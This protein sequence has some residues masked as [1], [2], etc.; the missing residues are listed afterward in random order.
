[1]GPSVIYY[2]LK[3]G[4]IVSL[5]IFRSIISISE[6][7]GIC[8]YTWLCLR[9]KFTECICALK[10]GILVSPLFYFWSSIIFYWLAACIPLLIL[11]LFHF[12]IMSFA[13][14]FICPPCFPWSIWIPKLPHFTKFYLGFYQ[15]CIFS[16]NYQGQSST[17]WI[18]WYLKY[19]FLDLYSVDWVQLPNQLHTSFLHIVIKGS[20]EHTFP[21]YW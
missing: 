10:W 1:M 18:P 20:V 4:I 13:F 2:F 11:I 12:V 19:V 6:W 7:L 5:I 9:T 16:I 17:F 14:I 21:L 3:W 15:K 8:V